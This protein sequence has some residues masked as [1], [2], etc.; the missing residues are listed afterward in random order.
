MFAQLGAK[1][2]ELSTLTD[3]DNEAD[4]QQILNEM[5]ASLNEDQ[6]LLKNW[7]NQL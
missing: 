7:I 5:P 3:V 6:V 2:Y 4:L 1:P